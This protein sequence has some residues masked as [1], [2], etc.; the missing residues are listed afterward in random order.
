MAIKRI[1]QKHEILS[2]Q[3]SQLNSTFHSYSLIEYHVQWMVRK[4]LQSVSAM[5]PQPND[6]VQ[7]Y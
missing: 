6:A 2:L 7:N 5:P 4:I 1:A 3:S